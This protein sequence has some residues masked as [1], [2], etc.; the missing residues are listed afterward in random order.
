MSRQPLRASFGIATLFSLFALCLSLTACSRSEARRPPAEPE[1]V[2]KAIRGY[3]GGHQALLVPGSVEKPDQSDE[4]YSAHI[5]NILVQE[6]FAQLE[7]I[8]RQNRVE[9]GRLLGRVW[10]NYAFYTGTN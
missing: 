1:V 9:K 4:A 10:K 2:M 5:R 8:A 3:G 6:D 7:K